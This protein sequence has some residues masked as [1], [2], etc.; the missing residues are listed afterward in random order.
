MKKHEKCVK[1]PR[2]SDLQPSTASEPQ[3]DE[4]NAPVP[5]PV[6]Q[7]GQPPPA[8]KRQLDLNSHV[9]H[10]PA[11]TKDDLDDKTAEFLYGCN[12]PFS[13]VEHPLFKSLVSSLRPGY[14]PP[15]RLAVSNKLLDKCHDKHQAVMKQLLNNKTV[16]M[17]QDGW[18]AVENDPVIA[19]SVV[20]DGKGY[21]VDTK[22]T[23]TSHNTAEACKAM[24]E[25]SK[26]HAESMYGCKVWLFVTDNAKNMDKMRRELEKEDANL[27]PY[28]CLYHVLNLLGQDLT[29]AP[30]MKHIVEVNKFFRNHHVPSAWLKSQLGSKR[31]QLPSETRW[32]G[33]LICLDSYLTNRT[34]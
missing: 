12:L 19:T 11:A 1:Q 18:S 29:P 34:R 24:F 28:G 31:P 17:Q 27:I 26:S 3:Q 13:I 16:T 15:S 20:S 23:G 9:V 6:S 30:I 10:T 2:S 25:G 33:Q 32:K 5:V 8:K 22:D 7:P 21:F 4:V 14:Q